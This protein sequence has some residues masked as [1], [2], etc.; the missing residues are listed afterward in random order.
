MIRPRLPLLLAAALLLPAASLAVEGE[1]EGESTPDEGGSEEGTGPVDLGEIS[2]V[3]VIGARQDALAAVPGSAALVTEEELEAARPADSGEVLRRVPGLHVRSEEGA[4]LRLNVGFRGLDPTRGRRL[5]VL[6]DGIPVA[7]NP[8]GEPDLYYSTPIERVASIEVVK[9][10]G[11]VLFGPQTIGGVLNLATV[12]P[13]SRT[14]VRLHA[15]YGQRDAL[16]LLGLYGGASPSLD[17]RW[18]LQV[19]HKRGDGF[20]EIGYEVTD[21]FGKVAFTTSPRSMATAKVGVYHETS[22]STYVGLTR[23]MY[24]DDPYRATVAP[25]DEFRVTRYDLSLVQDFD[26]G[27]GTELQLLAYGYHTGR[28]WRRQV[29][30]RSPVAGEWYVRIEGDSTIP[31]GAL[32]FRDSSRINDRTYRVF[33]V[34]PRFASTFDTGPL[35]HRLEYGGRFLVETADRDR[36]ETDSVTAD[37]GAHT[38]EEHQRTLAFAAH[39]Q[40]RISVRE[41]FHVVPGVRVEHV[42]SRREFLRRTVDGEVR[43]VAGPV[44]ESDV[45]AVVPG[46]GLVV[47]R[48]AAHAFA[49]VHLG[50]APPRVSTAIDSEGEDRQLDAERSV[51]Y[52]VGTRFQPL[53]WARLEA[54]GFVIDFQNEIIAA[55]DAGGAT[56]ELV[57][58]G[59]TFHAGVEAGAEVHLGEALGI[60]TRI[61]LGGQYTFSHA[62][63]R[64]GEHDGNLLPYAPLHTASARLDVEAPFGLGGGVAWTHVGAQFADAENTLEP[65]ASGRIGALAPYDV[66]DASVRYTIKRIG[67]TAAVT[68][69]GLLD[70]V[71]VASRLPDGIFPAGYRQVNVA[72]TWER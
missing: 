22:R 47:G 14:R 3:R 9:G 45:T 2:E 23:S 61:D 46:I 30:D 52:E 66:L 19:F 16:K 24:E 34:E 5:L 11:S 43:D 29:Y 55:S 58:G 50:F 49:G 72:L 59:Q 40:D 17:A 65:D 20:R 62:T 25:D 71:Y 60:P 6:E 63:F 69:K 1:D 42:R 41:V 13:P 36:Y 15:E 18:V 56:S 37:G 70:Q 12:A 8:Y 10:S 33:G 21:V 53:P 26:L 38:E 44:G 28:R 39:L 35:G 48:P 68:A 54:T 57:N 4:G 32:Y 64:G 51:N 31:E 7:I 27:R 67:L